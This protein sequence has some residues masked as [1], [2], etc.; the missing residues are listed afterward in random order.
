MITYWRI[1]P[2]SW[3]LTVMA[4]ALTGCGGSST[5]ESYFPPSTT[6]RAAIEKVL[7]DWCGKPQPESA[8]IPATSI[9]FIDFEKRAGRKLISFEI[10]EEQQ[11][12]NPPRFLV[13]L[14]FPDLPTD[15]GAVYLV[16][17]KDPLYVYR[18]TD[19][20]NPGM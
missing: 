1:N 14:Q 12:T 3:P 7:G 11:G 19:Y 16:V 9:E 18:D 2:R 4:I 6:S 5:V 20:E 13:K 8:P 10:Q 17:G 15:V